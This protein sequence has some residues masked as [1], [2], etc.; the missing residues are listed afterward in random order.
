MS[1]LLERFSM[2]ELLAE[3]TRRQNECE[4]I[5][6][7][8]WETFWEL[9]K[10]YNPQRR[11][12]E[13]EKW[14]RTQ[15]GWELPEGF[16]CGD[17]LTHN[18]QFIEIKFGVERTKRYVSWANIREEDSLDWFYLVGVSLKGTVYSFTV[19]PNVVFDLANNHNELAVGIGSDKWKYLTNWLDSEGSRPTVSRRLTSPSHR[20]RIAA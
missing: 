14:A 12:K 7:A 10:T 9:R 18:G 19:P 4:D 2:D 16:H 13:F 11:G 8:S 6:S 17:A 15:F 1:S 20:D 5:Y 3:I